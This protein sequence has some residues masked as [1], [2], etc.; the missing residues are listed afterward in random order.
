MDLHAAVV[1]SK[2]TLREQ[3]FHHQLINVMALAAPT[4][5]YIGFIVVRGSDYQRNGRTAVFVASG[6]ALAL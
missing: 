2:T 5:A 1:L 4:L 6:L 3:V